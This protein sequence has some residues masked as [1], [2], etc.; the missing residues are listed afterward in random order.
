MKKQ[1]LL[2]GINQYELLPELKYARQ[3]AESVEQALKQNYSFTEDEVILLTDAKPGLF[4]P[5]NRRIIEK[6]LEKLA[7]KELDLFIFGF[8][9]HGL[10]RNGQRYFCPLDA[11]SEDIEELGLPFSTLQRLLSRIKAKNTCLILD[12]CQKVHDRGEPETFTAADQNVMESIARDIVLDRKE[13]MPEFVSNVAILNSCKEGEAAYEW[14]ERKHGIFTAHLIDAMNRRF[15]SVAQIVGYTSRQVE[16]TAMELGKRQTPF[17]KLEGDISLPVETGSSPLITGDVFISYRHCN[18]DLV[19]PVEEELK[20]RGISFFIDRVGVNYGMEYSEA[21]TRA[22]VAS[23]LLLLFWTPEVKGSED[24]VN[25]VVLALRLKKVVIPYKIGDFNE[26]EHSRL[27]Y[28][29]ARL[30]HY[31][32]PQQTPQTIV[33]L[34]N[35][36]EQAMKGSALPPPVSSQPNSTSTV[37]NRPRPQTRVTAPPVSRQPIST[38]TAQSRPLSQTRVSAPPVSRQPISTSTAQNRPRSQTRVAAPPIQRKSTK[39]SAF[40]LNDAKWIILLSVLVFVFGLTTL[41]LF[42]SNRGK[43]SAATIAYNQLGSNAQGPNKLPASGSKAGERA[44]ITVDNIEFA[45]RWCPAGSFTMGAPKAEEREWMK[46]MNMS[47]VGMF[48]YMETQHEVILSKGFWMMETEVTV[49]MYKAFVDETGHKT[50]KL[51]KSWQPLALDPAPVELP[52]VAAPASADDSEPA[53]ALDPAAIPAIAADYA[54]P[55]PSI[56]Y[57]ENPYKPWDNPGFY[58]NDNHPVTNLSW[59]DADAFCEWLSNKTGQDIQLPTEAQWEYACRA[60][61]TGKFAG[62][63]DDMAWYSDNS[64]DKTHP[65]GTK[66]P[67]SWGLYD[68]HGNVEEW[69]QDWGGDYPSGRVTDPIG[70]SKQGLCPVF[71]GGCYKYKAMCCRSACREGDFSPTEL[72]CGFRCV[73]VQ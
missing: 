46:E 15:D 37:Q 6:H 8:W 4:K 61:T 52:A 67:N 26:V 21:L 51:W 58:Q 7:D 72:A 30:S 22:I 57:K 19:A 65:V 64:G 70:S 40:K 50:K 47:P 34:V 25:E 31:E 45:F 10:F 20:R 39:Q 62:N 27:C 63:L 59:E 68:M 24:I 14:D 12:C 1:A 41:F 13:R 9:G 71:R 11:I 56:E 66:K 42:I 32:V 2:I 44:V 55:T 60:G 3:D 38:P 28:H 49:G 48:Q 29:I 43:P 18:A 17:F 69:C 33:E 54:P 23:K 36:V 16:K 35:R 53:A 5:I 73:I